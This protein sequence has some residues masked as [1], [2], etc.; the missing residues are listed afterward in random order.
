MSS[1]TERPSFQKPPRQEG[2]PQPP[3]KHVERDPRTGLQVVYQSGE[4][5][6]MQYSLVSVPNLIPVK[7]DFSNPH[8]ELDF[9]MRRVGAGLWTLEGHIDSNIVRLLGLH[10]QNGETPAVMSDA[11][12]TTLRQ[13]GTIEVI[14]PNKFHV[15][16]NVGPGRLTRFLNGVWQPKRTTERSH[17]V[18]SI[19]LINDPYNLLPQKF[20]SER[21]KSLQTTLSVQRI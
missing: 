8:K 1:M 15:E 17:T 21:S 12:I 11:A 20:P 3:D 6:K 19:R 7:I 16:L 18:P 4:V 5:G 2:L 14:A 9:A 10:E 13:R